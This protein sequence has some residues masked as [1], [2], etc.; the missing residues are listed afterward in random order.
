MGLGR[1]FLNFFELAAGGA[2]TVFAVLL[3][4]GLGMPERTV[5]AANR[6]FR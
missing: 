6:R 1:L 3:A 4:L 5:V 2:A